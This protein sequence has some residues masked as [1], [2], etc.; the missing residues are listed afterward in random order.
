MS[1]KETAQRTYSKGHITSLYTSKWPPEIWI[2]RERGWF[3]VAS[4][5]H[6]DVQCEADAYHAA[7]SNSQ[8]EHPH[9]LTTQTTLKQLGTS[10]ED[11]LV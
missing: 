10:F 7:D 1:V 6:H 8:R 4:A 2:L 5:W 11:A 3:L 9:R